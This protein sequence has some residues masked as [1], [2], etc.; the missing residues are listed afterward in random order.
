MVNIDNKLD[1]LLISP[2][3]F[4]NTSDNIWTKVNSNFPPLG[5]ASIAA[6]ARNK[7]FSVK[8][9]DCNIESPSVEDFEIFFVK[10][11]VDKYNE[12]SV[13]GLTAM[14]PT[15]KKAYRIAEICR[16]FYPGALIVFGGVHPTFVTEE[17]IK[18]PFVDI[19]AVGEGEIT[20][21][22]ILEQ[23]EL[24]SI[25]GIVYKDKN[26]NNKIIYNKPRTRILN[27]DELPMPAY[28]LLPITEYRPAKGSYKRLPAMAMM[29]SRG[30]PGRCTFC[31]KTLGLQLFFKSAKIIFQEIKYL[32]DNYGIKEILFYDDTFT[33]HKRNVIEL[34]NLLLDNRIDITWTCFARVDFVDEEMLVKM[35]EAGCHQIM[36][37]VENTDSAVLL[38]IKKQINID[39]VFS[40]V[41][42]TK[43]AKIECRLAFMVGNPGDS[44][45]IVKKNIAVIKKLDPD[46][47]IVNITTPFPGT[48]MFAWAD[49]KG[50]LLSYDWDDYDL[51]HPVMRLENMDVKDIKKLYKIMYR[52]FYFRPRFIIKKILSIRSCEDF[53]VLFS[54]FTAL[55]SFFTIK[56]KK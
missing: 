44:V 33:V 40:A 16:K 42:W 26:D 41:K 56:P 21:W 18:Q 3:I 15:I 5:L 35:K 48:E 53:K 38:N 24:D 12:I 22:E 14:T 29:T 34:C 13:I 19:V 11:F 49:K 37:G 2:P 9:I 36:Y 50:L 54:G 8:M 32:V 52:S 4:Y 7:G 1:C 30:C 20:S 25:D 28:D 23:K 27:L 6:F 39:Q 45:A 31:A 17:V 51:A 55:L 47:L 46:L 10:N 43:Q